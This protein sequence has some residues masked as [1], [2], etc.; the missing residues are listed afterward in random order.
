MSTVQYN[1]LV[2]SVPYR[3]VLWQLYTFPYHTVQYSIWFFHFSTVPSSTLFGFYTGKQPN[4]ALTA[5]LS[6]NEGHHRVPLI[7]LVI[8]LYLEVFLYCSLRVT[9]VLV[10]WLFW[11]V[12]YD[13]DGEPAAWDI[14]DEVVEGDALRPHVPPPPTPSPPDCLTILKPCGTVAVHWKPKWFKNF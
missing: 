8:G 11:I 6:K 7:F 2:T 14:D 10:S 13:C 5:C 9:K 1:P 3:P 12:N 4:N